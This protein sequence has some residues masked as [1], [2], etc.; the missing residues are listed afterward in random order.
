MSDVFSDRIPPQN[1]EAEQA[2]LGCCLIEPEAIDVA[3]G[4]L[5]PGDFYRD[6]HRHIYEAI[7]S[8]SA[9]EE[10]VDLITLTDVLKA[11]NQ[12]DAVGGSVYLLNL[13]EAPSTAANIGVY[14]QNVR[15]KAILR[16]IADAGQRVSS[17]AWGPGAE[18]VEE[19]VRQ[20]EH[21]V[22]G[23]RSPRNTGDLGPI[24]ETLGAEVDRI[25]E[26]ADNPERTTGLG[27]PFGA[28]M[29]MTGGLNRG[30]FVVIGGR[31]GMGKTAINTQIV[32]HAAKVQPEPVV[33]FSLEMRKSAMMQ[34]LIAI[35]SGVDLLNIRLGHLSPDEINRIAE[36]SS[37]LVKLP[38]LIDDT[39]GIGV[40]DMRTK[41]RN[42]AHGRP[43]ALVSVDHIG[44][45]APSRRMPNRCSE[46][47][48]IAHALFALA[49]NFDVPLVALSQLNRDVDNQPGHR[50]MIS[51]LKECGTIE[52]N[53]DMVLFPLRPSYYGKKESVGGGDATNSIEQAELII[54]K[55]RQGPT[56]AIDLAFEPGPARFHNMFQDRDSAPQRETPAYDPDTGVL[57]RFYTREGEANG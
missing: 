15:D 2:V 38:I 31:P 19:A 10:P 3:A 48:E 41:L 13:L 49:G 39:R 29:R 46:L 50:P 42:Y 36:A 20:S 56:G 17:L 35:E 12:F 4:I 5:S 40:A 44:L 45:L 28:F 47:S 55:Q 52:E 14:A 32:L 18:N 1:L 43:L 37:R 51:N 22:S 24:S 11:R 16:E 8:L 23:I 21:I 34:R 7:V 54:A 6:A 30:E 26:R 9:R 25:F 33:L 27:V 57:D 53:A